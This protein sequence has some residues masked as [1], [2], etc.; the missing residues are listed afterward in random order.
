[1]KHCGF[2][3]TIALSLFTLLA[4]TESQEPQTAQ[5]STSP[6][7][8]EV[9]TKDYKVAETFGVGKNVYVR[10]MAIDQKGQTL[11][12]GTST[13]VLEVDTN[14][15]NMLNTYTRDNG[16]ANEY[17]FSIMVDSEGDKWLGTNGGGV[18]RY[19]NGKWITYFPMHG[20]ADYWVYAFTEQKN[21]TIWIGTWAGLNSFNKNTSEFKTYLKELVNEWVYGLAVDSQDR[22]WIGTEG[23][24]NMF[25]GQTWQTWTHKEGLG[26]PNIAGLPI[27]PNTGL[28]TRDRHDLSVML[29]GRATYNPNY[30][31]T[32]LVTPDDTVWAGTWG[33]GASHYDGSAWT[34][35]T[36]E[37][38][39]AGNIVYVIARDRSGAL[40][41][42]TNNGLSRF[43]GTTWQTYRTEDGLLD[44]NIYA[45]TVSGSGQVWV[46]SRGGVVLLR[47]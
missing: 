11:W 33:G 30:T 22:V 37:D 28:G 4:C 19:S 18:S 40:W 34:N 47:R 44:N 1:M 12:V 24:I 2:I 9:G 43:D 6:A 20:L 45:I 35:Y 21:G 17:V 26:A 8:R 13:G 31:F 14:T 41:F 15:Y 32:L 46:G 5:V 23:G 39:L 10:S 25:D 38:G 3:L 7:P 16:L 42:G 29:E 27:S 36:T